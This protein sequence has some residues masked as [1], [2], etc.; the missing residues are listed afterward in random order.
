MTAPVRP[1]PNPDLAKLRADLA[2]LQDAVNAGRLPP[3]AIQRYVQRHQSTPEQEA[4]REPLSGGDIARGVLANAGEGV[5]FSFADELMGGLRGIIDPSISMGEG[6]DQVRS[7]R[8][9][10]ADAH[11]K[12]A[13]G[14]TLGGAALPAILTAGA[15]TA[16]SAAPLAARVAAS[17]AAGGAVAGYGSGEGGPL[18]GSRVGRGLVGG[19][20]GY[21]L[22]KALPPVAGAFRESVA[23]GQNVTDD[24]LSQLAQRS[25]PGATS[26]ASTAA[27]VSRGT[28]APVQS[29][30]APW[31]AEGVSESAQRAAARAMGD[32]N[33]AR[34][35]LSALEAG[36]MGDEALA[37]NAG[38]DRTVRAVRAAANMPNSDAGQLV[39]ERLARQGGALGEQVP[40]DIGTVTG[41]GTAYPEVTAR[42]MQRDLS[43]KVN[44]GYEAFRQRGNLAPPQRVGDFGDDAWEGLVEDLTNK[45]DIFAR[46]GGA[47]EGGRRAYEVVD[48]IDAFSEFARAEQ[49][50]ATLWDALKEFEYS[51]AADA[52]SP[53]RFRQMRSLLREAGF[54]PAKRG[55][56]VIS[57]TLDDILGLDAPTATAFRPYLR[58]AMQDVELKG[59]PET[60]ARVIDAA[61]KKL[62]RQYRM[63]DISER[64]GVGKDVTQI[65]A[66]NNLRQRVLGA[67]EQVDPNYAELGRTYALDEDVGKVVQEGFE[68]GRGIKTPGQATVAMDDAARV[69]GAQKAVRAGNVASLQSAARRGASNADLGDLAQ[70][71]D[72]A[73]AVVGTPE[74]R[75]T[76]IALHGQDVY[77]DLLARL[78]PKIKA[79]AQ[80]AAARGNSTTAK[81][82]LDALAFGDD[83][84]LDVLNSLASGSP[85]RGLVRSIVGRAVKPVDR[86]VRLGVGK[87]ATETADLL[88]TKGSTEIRSLLDLLES[89]GQADAARAAR[90]Q[91]AAATAVRGLVGAR[92]P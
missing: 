57:Q 83:A 60:D 87:T 29:P 82:L 77:D 33:A 22:G 8:D 55:A 16:G 21:A 1:T 51:P 71:R 52:L 45:A 85:G 15:S 69:P 91:P 43:A 89:L 73:R 37:M 64:A 6:I 90:A 40:G 9:R 92:R 34:A 35:N 2:V 81:Q 28:S 79:A 47:R 25:A 7:E 49:P 27:N 41:F 32:P 3:E 65:D 19:V 48:A 26:V 54:G 84:A 23:G 20:A 70:F 10:F 13:L 67:I 14:L 12:T 42:N 63:A 31:R 61:F 24:L 5:G 39:N 36:G 18:S 50:H 75:Q 78:M 74:S 38:T 76:F 11:P 17:G 66:L 80:N 59:L 86:A 68:T 44:E 56:M 53:V 72:V 62:Q 58:S 46:G 4:A 30:N 88:T